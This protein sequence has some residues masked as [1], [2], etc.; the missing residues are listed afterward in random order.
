MDGGF[1]SRYFEKWAERWIKN[2]DRLQSLENFQSSVAADPNLIQNLFG[3]SL[4]IHPSN[5]V[6]IKLSLYWIIKL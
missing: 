1:Q 6:I 3:L 2:D 5:H 4:K